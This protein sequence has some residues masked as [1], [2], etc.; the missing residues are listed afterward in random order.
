ML[1]TMYNRC[2]SGLT[3]FQ[4]LAVHIVAT[5]ITV[6]RQ[7]CEEGIRSSK[8]ASVQVF[9]GLLPEEV[10]FVNSHPC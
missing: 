1:S 7:C 8:L 3:T 2:I 5:G 6:A 10:I 9:K 4:V